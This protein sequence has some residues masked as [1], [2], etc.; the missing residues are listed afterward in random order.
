MITSVQGEVSFNS[1]VNNP[2]LFEVPIPS[3]NELSVKVTNKYGNLVNFLNND[4]SFTLR[5]Y[6]IIS[7]PIETKLVQTNYIEEVIKKASS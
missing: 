7:N 1:F 6:E 4:F 3:L 2:V 5:I